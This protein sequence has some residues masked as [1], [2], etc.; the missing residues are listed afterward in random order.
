[1]VRAEVADRFVLEETVRALLNHDPSEELP[2]EHVV[3]LREIVRELEAIARERVQVTE[4]D[5]L[6]SSRRALL[7]RLGTRE[8]GL[9]A[10][11]AELTKDAAVADMMRQI[12]R[13][14][15]TDEEATTDALVENHEFT[16]RR[17]RKL[18]LRQQRFL[19]EKFGTYEV[20]DRSARGRVRRVRA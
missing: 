13:P 14:D 18:S 5:G 10:E 9:R 16:G 6:D 12:T 3:R 1:V 15:P 8:R 11:S 4:F 17:L 19:V 7:L 20:I 2:D